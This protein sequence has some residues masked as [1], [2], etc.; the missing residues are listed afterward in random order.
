M[1]QQ[2]GN[3]TRRDRLPLKMPPGPLGIDEENQHPSPPIQTRST[4]IPATLRNPP[5]GPPAKPLLACDNR[6][7]SAV[8]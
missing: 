7:L 5:T 2:P 3:I 1:T 8:S 4:E 6:Q